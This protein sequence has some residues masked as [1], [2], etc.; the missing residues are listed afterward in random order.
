MQINIFTVTVTHEPTRQVAAS[1]LPGCFHCQPPTY[2][3]TLHGSQKP[4]TFHLRQHHGPRASKATRLGHGRHQGTTKFSA[5]Q[6]ICPRRRQGPGRSPGA[7]RS[8]PK[9]QPHRIEAHGSSTQ[10]PRTLTREHIVIL[11]HVVQLQ[12]FVQ[13]LEFI[14]VQHLTFPVWVAWGES[15]TVGALTPGHT[16]ETRPSPTAGRGPDTRSPALDGAVLWWV[17]RTPCTSKP[18]T[19]TTGSRAARLQAPSRCQPLWG[20]P[21]AARPVSFPRWPEQPVSSG[22]ADTTHSCAPSPGG[23]PA[24]GHGGWLCQ[25]PLCVFPPSRPRHVLPTQPY[26]TEAATKASPKSRRDQEP[27]VN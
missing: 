23:A 11:I 9:P 17:A 13:L 1:C 19:N 27:N 3:L 24:P 14:G 5:A 12:A 21:N 25:P 10:L 26:K 6:P 22:H 15:R 18:P 20:Q 4:N 8:L 16:R 2:P 7:G